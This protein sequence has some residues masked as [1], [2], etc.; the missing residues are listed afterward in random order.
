MT[1]RVTRAADGYRAVLEGQDG[2][3]WASPGPQSPDDVL[4]ELAIRGCASADIIKALNAADLE[5]IRNGGASSPSWADLD[6]QRAI[7]D[8]PVDGVTPVT[9][10]WRFVSIGFENDPIDIGGGI[11]PWLG[12]WLSLYRRIVVGHPQY[13]RQRHDMDTYQLAGTDPPVVFA[14]GEFSNGV[15][16]FFVPLVTPTTI[17]PR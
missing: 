12:T 6:M 17:R 7:R 3:T 1:I 15:W 14:A 2:E 13:P 10:E 8:R 16:G 5:W 9:P 4:H 11:N